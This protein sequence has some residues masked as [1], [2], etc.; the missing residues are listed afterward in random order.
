[1]TTRGAASA[2]GFGWVGKI[3]APPAFFSI[4]TVNVTSS[5]ASLSFTSIPQTYKHLELRYYFNGTN[6]NGPGGPNLT[7]NNDSGSNYRM[8][9]FYAVL[10]GPSTGLGQDNGSFTTSGRLLNTSVQSFSTNAPCMGI[11]HIPDY[12]SSK[13]KLAISESGMI[14]HAAASGYYK[15]EAGIYKTIWNST[16][17]I[18][19]ISLGTD[20]NWGVGTFALYGIKG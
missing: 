5:T 4:A 6:S 11:V 3:P 17:A 20:F 9:S 10:N 2:R 19:T 8:S 14:D 18:T 12:T 13:L 15:K 7:F 16:A 1:L